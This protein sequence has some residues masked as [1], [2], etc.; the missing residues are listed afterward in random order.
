MERR[1]KATL[2][3]WGVGTGQDKRVRRKGE[4]AISRFT[5]RTGRVCA[6]PVHIWNRNDNG[7][8]IQCGSGT[9]KFCICT[10]AKLFTRAHVQCQIPTFRVK[11]ASLI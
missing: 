11:R 5:M 6:R 9:W 8:D 1:K 3:A 2:T 10:M 4:N 7:Q